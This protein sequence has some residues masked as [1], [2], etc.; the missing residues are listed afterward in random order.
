MK[1]LPLRLRNFFLTLACGLFFFYVLLPFVND[2]IPVLRQTSSLLEEHD[3]DPSR[4]YYTDVE[5]VAEGEAYL[6]SVLTPQ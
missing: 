1:S 6:R 3:I 5:Q 4:Y 2:T